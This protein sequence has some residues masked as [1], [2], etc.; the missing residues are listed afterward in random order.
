MSDNT[1]SIRITQLQDLH[2]KQNLLIM[3]ANKLY[4]P[5]NSTFSFQI[6]NAMQNTLN[7]IQNEIDNL[8]SSL[9]ISV[10]V[11]KPLG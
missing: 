2:A 11:E 5:I 8:R 7:Q 6:V 4:T 10:K 9:S 1:I 3:D